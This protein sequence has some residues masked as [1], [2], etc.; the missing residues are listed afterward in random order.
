MP[1]FIPEEAEKIQVAPTWKLELI[2]E[3]LPY[4]MTEEDELQGKRDWG[5]VGIKDDTD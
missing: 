5:D 4:M 1:H 2:R 3:M